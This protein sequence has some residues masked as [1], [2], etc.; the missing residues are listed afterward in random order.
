VAL[1]AKID[2]VVVKMKIA[3]SETKNET[4]DLNNLARLRAFCFIPS[5]GTSGEGRVRG[6]LTVR[7]LFDLH[8]LKKPSPQP[9]A[10]EIYK[11]GVEPLLLRI[12]DGFPVPSP[13]TGLV[14]LIRFPSRKPRFFTE[15]KGE[16]AGKP[17][18]STSPTPGEG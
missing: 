10:D 13:G 1:V 12:D 9:W 7:I 14:D 18:K 4:R 17:I 15:N 6:S 2:A 5:P 16:N 11:V 8:R 3:G